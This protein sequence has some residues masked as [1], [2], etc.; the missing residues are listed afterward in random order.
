MECAFCKIIFETEEEKI[1]KDLENTKNELLKGI[2]KLEQSNREKEANS[3]KKGLR[4]VESKIEQLEIINK[5]CPKCESIIGKII[6]DKLDAK[7]EDIFDI[8]KDSISIE[9]NR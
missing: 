5:L 4:K 7:M 8:I 3:S 2:E 1:L 9:F 6:E